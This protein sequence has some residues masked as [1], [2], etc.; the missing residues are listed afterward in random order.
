MAKTKDVIID[1]EVDSEGKMIKSR[2]KGNVGEM[3]KCFAAA[4]A[5]LVEM[6][7]L[8]K[9]DIIC[10]FSQCLDNAFKSDDN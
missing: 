9:D 2:L 8:N 4:T 6:H 7:K 3:L 10:Y 5:Y 1:L